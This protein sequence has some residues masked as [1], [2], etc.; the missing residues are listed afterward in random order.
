VLEHV[1]ATSGVAVPEVRP[2]STVGGHTEH[3]S[4]L[5]AEMQVVARAHPE[6]QW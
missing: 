6:G 3:L 4:R 5:L 2:I 1:L